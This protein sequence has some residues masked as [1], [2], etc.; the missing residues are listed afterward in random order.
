MILIVLPEMIVPH[1]MLLIKMIN[2]KNNKDRQIIKDSFDMSKDNIIIIIDLK[3][4]NE[5]KKYLT[6][7]IFIINNKILSFSIR[8]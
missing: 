3:K 2:N 7:L 1:I 6:L 8:K 4:F 5:F